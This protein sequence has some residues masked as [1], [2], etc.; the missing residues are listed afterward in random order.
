MDLLVLGPALPGPALP[1]PALPGP[2]LLKASLLEWVNKLFGL[3]PHWRAEPELDTLQRIIRQQTA[4]PFA[5][6]DVTIK[7]FAQ[8]AFNK[9]YTIRPARGHDGDSHDRSDKSPTTTL[10]FRASLPVCPRYKTESEAATIRFVQERTSVPVPRIYAFDS[11]LRPDVGFEWIIMERMPGKPLR[12]QW[13]SMSIDAKAALVRTVAQFQAEL[14]RPANRF[15]S[16]G[17]ILEAD[18]DSVGIFRIGPMVSPVFFW[19]PQ[20]QLDKIS[21]PFESSHDWLLARLNV[22]LSEQERII[23]ETPHDEDRQVAVRSL[24]CA[25]KLCR[26]LPKFFPPSTR[27]ETVLWHHDLSD[28]N[29]LVS[30]SGALAAIVD[31]ECVSAVPMWRARDIPKFLRGRK[32]LLPVQADD[33]GSDSESD[34]ESSDDEPRLDNQGKTELYWIHLLEYEQTLL[35]DIYLETM[36]RLAPRSQDQ[37][38]KHVEL[39]DFESAVTLCDHELATSLVTEWAEDNARGEVW[40]LR[41][42]LRR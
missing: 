13:R 42:A 1:G 32:R 37:R 7:P 35:R 26:L 19:G 33:Y 28:N 34:I 17:N 18:R 3:E 6:E 5:G 25:Q 23:K 22:M 41:E 14:L 40:N 15:T 10:L 38:A 27:E 21:G 39:L 20:K 4:L 8:G 12:Q 30:D 16:L 36:E 29:I 31:W 24:A 11:N 2:A 9:L